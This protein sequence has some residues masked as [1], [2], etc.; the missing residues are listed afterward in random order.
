MLNTYQE[1]VSFRIVIE[2]GKVVHRITLAAR[3]FLDYGSGPSSTMVSPQF[4]GVGGPM[5]E[6]S[7]GTLHNYVKTVDLKEYLLPGMNKV[8]IQYALQSIAGSAWHSVFDEVF[9]TKRGA[10]F[11]AQ[12][13]AV[14]S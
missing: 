10:A 8:Y 5:L 13:L 7:G 12:S 4:R 9:L 3:Q 1:L 14:T 2:N 6:V 11:A